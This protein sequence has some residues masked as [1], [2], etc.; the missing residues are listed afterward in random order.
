MKKHI[1]FIV[2]YISFWMLMFAIM[3]FLFILFNGKIASEL[4]IKDLALSFVHGL[5]LDLS[6][7]A[8]LTVIPV[9]LWLLAQFVPARWPDRILTTY[10]ILVMII[11]LSITLVDA[12]LYS[13]WGQKLN[14]YASSFARFPKEMLSFSSGVSWGKLLFFVLF[15]SFLVKIT[16]DNVTLRFSEI[17]TTL[18]AWVTLL[19]FI[20]FGA[21][22]F[23]MIRGNIGMSPINQSFAYF[24]D[25]PFL[26][27]AAVNTTWNFMASLT[28]ET[29]EE[30]KN[31]YSFLKDQEAEQLVDS[32]FNQHTAHAPLK[33]TNLQKPDLLLIILE[34][35]TADVVAF[36]GG[37]NGVTP[38]LDRLAQNSLTYTQF[39][40]NGNRTDKGLAAILS[41]QP[42]LAKSSIINK[43]QKF[44]NLPAL[45]KSLSM[46]GYNSTFVYGGESEFAN[47]KA[48]WINSGY[49]NIVDIHQFNKAILPENWGV[50]DNE[51][52]DKLL[53]VMNNTTSPR[54]VT[55]LTLSSHEPY[56]VPH[57]SNF[58][59]STEGDKYRNS[60]HFSD[61]C[62]GHFLSQAEKQPWYNNTLIFILSDHAHQEPL[63]RSAYEPARF[64]IPFVV[65]GGAL[66]PA[67]KGVAVSRPA[68]QTDLAP[69]ILAQLGADHQEYRWGT[70]LFDTTSAAFASYTYN[71]GIGFI[72]DNGYVVYDHE[73][74]RT[75]MASGPDSIGLTKTARAYQ[76]VF[77]NEYLQR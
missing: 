9:L 28:D 32:L 27:H 38:N 52:Y 45:P 10:N 77:Y 11:V 47:M 29:E 15:S 40:A 69:G 54:L 19:T 49:N 26:N 63:G 23:L 62:L 71:D 53:K 76:Q 44:S 48:Y 42:A 51:L 36:T 68:Q 4:P 35:W 72:N 18:K 58:S 33:L 66:N 70:N 60:V 73:A 74:R 13:Y 46:Q 5:R 12:Q 55:A 21:V 50:H 65:T 8:Y 59:G 64:H 39:Y 7:S 3:R 20:L 24:S 57:Q 31:P 37:E 41:A 43:L 61:E 22:L 34:G 1:E 67:L 75:I 17:G 2:R 6:T 14:A 56:H 16:Y 25:K 30:K